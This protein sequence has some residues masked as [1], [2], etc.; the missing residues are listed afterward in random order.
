MDTEPDPIPLFEIDQKNSDISTVTD[1]IERGSYWAKGPYVDD[2]ESKLEQYLGVKHAIVVNSGTTALVAALKALGIGKDDEVIIPSFT[3]I[4]TANA[5]R[6]VGAEPVFADIEQDQYGLSPASVKEKIT[7][8]TEAILPVHPYGTSCH[9]KKLLT[10][11]HQ[12]DIPIVEDSAEVLGAEYD[13]QKLGT[14]GSLAALSFCQNKIISTGEGGAVVTDDEDLAEEVKLFRSHGRSSIDYFESSESGQYTA[15]GTNIR[16]SDLTAAL[17]CSQIERIDTLIT[18]RRKAAEQ[19]DQGFAEIDGVRPHKCPENGTH[20]YQLYTVE[21]AKEIDRQNV[22]KKLE[23][24]NIASKVY[25]DPPV[26]HTEYYRQTIDEVPELPN[27][28]E[29]SSRVIS[30]PMHPNL[31]EDETTRIVEAVA[32]AVS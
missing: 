16:M 31:S 21:L 13:G 28:E 11:A 30:L 17:G 4:A 10:I 8:S 15:L 9:I 27:T 1:S 32:M 12:Y 29:I 23:E 7:D 22:I 24:R 14:F 18:G 5:I 6:L 2:F 3:F 25:W 26:H 19:L 20:V